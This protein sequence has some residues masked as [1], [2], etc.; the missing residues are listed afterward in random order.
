MPGRKLPALLDVHAR[1]LRMVNEEPG[2]VGAA[3]SGADL[4]ATLLREQAPHLAYLRARPSNAQGSSNS[5]FRLGDAYAVRPPRSE[6]YVADLLKE[7]QWLPRLGPWLKAAVPEVV[8]TGRPSDAFPRPW[9][10]VTWVPGVMPADLDTQ[11]QCALAATLGE[12]LT[13]LHAVDTYGLS[14]GASDWGYR[15]GEPVT[16]EIDSWAERAA[17]ALSDLFDAPRSSSQWWRWSP[18]KSAFSCAESGRAE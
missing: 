12:F 9:L 17:A 1:N 11:R 5:V 8:F 14:G 10:V 13:G 6:N 3:E 7:A 16:D 15:C 18:A 2:E 4:V